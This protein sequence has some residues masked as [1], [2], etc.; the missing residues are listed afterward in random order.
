MKINRANVATSIECIPQVWVPDRDEVFFR[1]AAEIF[2]P[3]FTLGANVL[4]SS[5][6]VSEPTEGE[7]S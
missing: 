1:I 7:Q 6:D 2:S 3:T 5:Y 4:L